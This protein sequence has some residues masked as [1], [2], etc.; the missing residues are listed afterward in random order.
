MLRPTCTDVEEERV[1]ALALEKLYC[2]NERGNE[3]DKA[4]IDPI[5]T[6]IVNIIKERKDELHA[7][8]RIS[9][10][11]PLSFRFGWS[12]FIIIKLPLQSD[13]ANQFLRNGRNENP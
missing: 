7:F 2:H 9:L 5:D 6:S 3:R 12:F 13:F 8:A 10:Y 1:L 4:K 11:D